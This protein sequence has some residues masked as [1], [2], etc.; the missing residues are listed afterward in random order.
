[1]KRRKNCK[2]LGLFLFEFHKNIIYRKIFNVRSIFKLCVENENF[3]TAKKATECYRYQYLYQNAANCHINPRCIGCVCNHFSKDCTLKATVDVPKPLPKC[4]NYRI[5]HYSKY[6]GCSKFPTTPQF[7]NLYA[8][9]T[10]ISS[11]SV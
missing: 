9:I 5:S 6:K 8:R 4:C 1:M 10:A 3:R 7:R 11:P 2:L